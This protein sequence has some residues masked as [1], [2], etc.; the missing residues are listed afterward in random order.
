MVQRRVAMVWSAPSIT[1]RGKATMKQKKYLVPSLLAAGIIPTQSLS[2]D[3]SQLGMQSAESYLDKIV[4]IVEDIRTSHTYTLAQHRSHQSHRS[5]YY[6]PPVNNELHRVSEISVR[7]R[8][9]SSTPR[10]S[11]LPSSPAIVKKVKVLPGNS[12]KFTKLVTRTQVALVT[13]GYDVGIINGEIH[14]KT[15]AAIYKYQSK[16]GII[17]TGK[18]TNETLSSLGIIAR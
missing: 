16:S 8:N 5:G 17:P 6:S 4:G 9:E 7:G 14:A 18:L 15:I 1:E 12:K 10:S 2:S 13:K 3:N 11:L